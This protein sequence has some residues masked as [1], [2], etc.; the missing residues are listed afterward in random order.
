MQLIMKVSAIIAAAGT[1][2]R[3]GG[4][5]PKQYLELAGRPVICHTLDCIRD[6]RWI[7]SVVVVVE[8]GRESSFKREILEVEGYPGAWLVTAGGSF[9]QESVAKGLSMVPAECD[10][11]LVHDGVRPFVTPEIMERASEVA[12]RDGACI[13]AARVKETIKRANAEGRIEETV[14]RDGLWGAQTPQ[15]FRRELLISAM[16]RA[17]RENFVGTDESSIVERVG[18]RVT[19]LEGDSRNIKITTPDDLSVAEALLRNR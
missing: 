19:V 12:F 2:K 4:N 15:C 13:V 7:D 5:V 18:A 1:G 10:V 9:R 17:R 6:A 14:D 8:P 3:M 11:V 16:E